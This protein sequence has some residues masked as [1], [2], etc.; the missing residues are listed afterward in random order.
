MKTPLDFYPDHRRIEG[1]VALWLNQAP[2]IT[3]TRVC[4][5]FSTFTRFDSQSKSPE[6]YL[7]SL[8]KM[9]HP[10]GPSILIGLR[11]SV[12]Q[13]RMNLKETVAGHNDKSIAEYPA[14]H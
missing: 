11:I 5:L 9:V 7:T 4:L 10:V 1:I 13:E 6:V 14:A 8:H 12:Q 3:S 2:C